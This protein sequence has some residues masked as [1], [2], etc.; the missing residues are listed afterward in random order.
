MVKP[1]NPSE[2]TPEIRRKA[3]G[4]LMFLKM[5]TDGGIKARGCADGRPQRVYEPRQETS[6][7]TVAVESIFITSAVA[8]KEHRGV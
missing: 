2:I 6:S 8:A 3:L 4:Y 1:L 7:P 5:K